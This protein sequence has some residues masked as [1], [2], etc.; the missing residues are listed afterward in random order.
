MRSPT[1]TAAR[2]GA[3]AACANGGGDAAASGAAAAA[4]PVRS[5]PMAMG[6]M[7][8]DSA[9]VMLHGFCAVQTGGEPEGAAEAPRRVELIVGGDATTRATRITVVVTTAAAPG[10]TADL[11][12]GRDAHAMCAGPGRSIIIGGTAMF[13]GRPTLTLT[14][15]GPVTVLARTVQA[16][17][18]AGPVEVRAGSPP[19]VLAWGRAAP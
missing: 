14:S 12:A 7:A 2:A 4:P 11:T 18:L 9:M 10:L 3:L 15:D 13:I 8:V 17:T 19:A 1:T 6:M 5:A 16:E